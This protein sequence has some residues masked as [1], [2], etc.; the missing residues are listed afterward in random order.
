MSV[1]RVPSFLSLSLVAYLAS[2]TLVFLLTWPIPLVGW[3][4]ALALCWG[5]AW[6]LC[7]DVVIASPST[8]PI[9][10][11]LWSAIFA[12]AL[13]WASLGGAGHVFYANEYDW[14]VRDALLADLSRQLGPL[15]VR[16]SSEPSLWLLRCPLGYYL[17]PSIL[18]H[19]FGLHWAQLFLFGWTFFG[20]FLSFSLLAR[21]WSNWRGMLAV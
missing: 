20:V 5:C 2:P 3:T 17:V 4:A 19:R 7:D 6:I 9:S 21:R 18:A 8:G 16:T 10:L 15:V 12:V 13:A 1:R 11:G 14:H